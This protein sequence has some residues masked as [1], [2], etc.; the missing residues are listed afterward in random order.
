MFP[1]VSVQSI[2]GSNNR[3][4]LAGDWAAGTGIAR[5]FL[6]VTVLMIA[7]AATLGISAADSRLVWALEAASLVLGAIAIWRA[8]PLRPSIAIPLAAIAVWGFAQ[9]EVGATVY[10]YHTL[11]ASLRMAA[12]VAVAITSSAAFRS[13][14]SREILI[15]TLAWFGLVVAIFGV[16]AHKGDAWGLFASR[17][18]FAQFLELALPAAIWR[19]RGGS[20]SATAIAGTILAA[21]LA[22]ASRAGAILLAIETIGCA[23]LLRS[24]MNRASRWKL[25]AASVPLIAIAGI[26]QLRSRL[27][28][29]DPMEYRREFARSTGS[30]IGDHPWRG[31]GL[32]TFVD[33]YPAY[34]LFDPGAV[35]DHAHNDWLEWAAEG[36][37]GFLVVWVA[38]AIVIMPVAVRSIWGIGALAVF[39]HALVDYPFA[40]FGIAAWVFVI[41]GALAIEKSTAAAAPNS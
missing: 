10:G 26:S 30:M 14:R 38:L 25:A 33:V 2:A 35:V 5:A 17:N 37:V 15:R 23:I 11:D 20:L 13:A 18:K 8:P 6:P 21:G 34:A 1:E 36:G 22:S 12:L 19:A 40:K 7:A 4:R 31:F 29:A 41:I 9:L 32:G 28:Q 16:V 24:R 27:I 3:V 39:L